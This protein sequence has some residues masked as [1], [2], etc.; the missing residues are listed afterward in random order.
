MC[1]M[2]GRGNSMHTFKGQKTALVYP[3]MTTAVYH[4]S[5]KLK[6]VREEAVESSYVMPRRCPAISKAPVV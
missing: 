3:R 6:V 1:S 4:Q 2:P 5:R